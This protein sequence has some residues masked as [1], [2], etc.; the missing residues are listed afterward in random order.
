MTSNNTDKLHFDLRILEFRY[1]NHR[2]FSRCSRI[3]PILYFFC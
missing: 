1:D 3:Y 2:L